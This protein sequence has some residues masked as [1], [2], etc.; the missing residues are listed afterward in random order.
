MFSLSRGD[1]HRVD[2]RGWFET[3]VLKLFGHRFQSHPPPWATKSPQIFPS[4][5]GQSFL[6]N[7]RMHRVFARQATLVPAPPGWEICALKASQLA[8]ALSET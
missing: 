2:F 1:R 8:S 7:G 6:I 5:A 3:V 4:P